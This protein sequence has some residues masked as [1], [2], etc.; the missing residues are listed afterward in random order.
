MGQMRLMRLMGL[1]GLIGLMSLSLSAQSSDP[2]LMT[3]NGHAVKKSEFVYSY[4]HHQAVSDDPLSVEDYLEQF[5]DYKLKVAAALDAGYTLPSTPTDNQTGNAYVAVVN[6]AEA[7]AYYRQLCSSAGQQDM[8]RL[9]E[10][11]LP[12]DTRASAAVV[13]QVK[14][15]ADS[16][17][18]ALQ[19]GADFSAMARRLSADANADNGGDMGWVGPCQLLEDVE[20][21]AYQLRRGDISQPVL[22]PAGWHILKVVDRQ[23]A[24]S[25]VVRQWFLAPRE[26]QRHLSA[27][28]VDADQ[29]RVNG[30]DMLAY[31][32]TRSAV[33]D[34][35]AP[36]DDVLKRFFKKNKKRYGKK[37]KK[38]D[39]AAY[40]DMVLADYMQHREEEWVES[41]HKRYK[42]KVNKSILKTIE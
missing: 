35:A 12:V 15:R 2:V 28:D 26:A 5:T 6:T 7:E 29:A 9:S 31:Q 24:G 27:V 16:V 33:W 40:R 3:V 39:Y 23:P 21:A 10:I 18:R 19:G 38:R 37:L 25:E 17:Y 42:V 13:S 8:L 20:R 22:S 1:I 41:L 34:K 36:S 30:E 32:I 4:R 11:L 14:Q